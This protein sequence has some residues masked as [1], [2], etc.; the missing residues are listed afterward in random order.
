M[1]YL[2]FCLSFD[3]V[4]PDVRNCLIV[5][6][7]DVFFYMIIEF[8]RKNIICFVFLLMV[9]VAVSDISN[10]YYI[11]DFLLI[12]PKISKSMHSVRL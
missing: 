9:I 8:L 11:W 4:L 3:V 1:E 6:P 10:Y 12:Q 5:L 2:F 7:F